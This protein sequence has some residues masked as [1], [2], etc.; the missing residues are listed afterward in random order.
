MGGEED[1]VG[2]YRRT[3]RVTVLICGRCQCAARRAS[4]GAL[5][6]GG[7]TL[8]PASGASAASTAAGISAT[9]N[10]LSRRDHGLGGIGHEDGRMN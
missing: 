2:L 8:T 5:K 10:K 6:A 3:C 1:G 7:P 9:P 4:A